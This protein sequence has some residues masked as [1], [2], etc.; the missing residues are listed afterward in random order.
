MGGG[1][2]NTRSYTTRT[3]AKIEAGEDIFTHSA[4]AARTGDYTVHETV[5]PKRVNNAGDHRGM[6]TRESLDSDE[7]PESLAIAVLFDV[8]GSMQHLPRVIQEKLPKLYG[9]LLEK[10]YVEHPQILYGAVGDANSDRTPLQV[11]QFESDNRADESLENLI[12]EGGGGGGN[13]ESY[14]LA[15]YFMANHT[16]TDCY[17]KRG[18]K[19][20]MF[21]IGDE[22]VYDTVR[23][24]H[25]EQLIGD[26]LQENL[27]TREV[28]EQL[29]EKWEVF[30]LFAEEGSYDVTRTL[31]VA[32]GDGALGWRDLLGQN[33]IVLDD[34]RAVCE[35]IALTIGLNEGTIDLDT[36]L[37]H[38]RE[39]GTEKSTTEAVG[40]AL[41]T[42]S[43]GGG[44]SV[45]TL[46]G[47][48][49]GADA[50]STERL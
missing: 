5:D 11:G 9:M 29:A 46:E 8:T 21:L 3:E 36:G 2:W 22:R 47:D 35:V 12:L 23:R 37:T 42:V 30:F 17:E 15:A 20:Y 50:G 41:A 18:K 14:E 6:M 44:G 16:Y 7:H 43:A 40:K 25:V 27:T 4:H 33:A 32:P 13:H 1:S 28:F 49:P 38:L 31:D 39:L 45:A 10:G 24:D 48:F 26:G 19:G 34:T